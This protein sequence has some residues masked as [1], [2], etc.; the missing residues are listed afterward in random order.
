MRGIRK[1]RLPNE[2]SKE[3]GV[4]GLQKARFHPK[5]RLER[6]M[7]FGVGLDVE[8]E[9]SYD[10]SHQCHIALGSVDQLETIKQTTETL[11]KDWLFE[12]HFPNSMV[13]SIFVLQC[14]TFQHQYTGHG[15][16]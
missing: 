8:N 16:R 12:Y 2:Q 15:R 3:N 7:K 14:L 6:S 11:R 10:L 1:Q 4:S 13:V 5:L 9:S